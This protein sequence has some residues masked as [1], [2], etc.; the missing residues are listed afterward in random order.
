MALNFGRAGGTAAVSIDE[1]RCT[2]CGL[3]VQVC[4]GGPLTMQGGYSSSGGRVHVDQTRYWGCIGCGHCMTVCPQGCIL[5]EGR[6][7]SPQDRIEIPAPAARAGYES[8]YALLLSRR[9]TRAFRDQEVE[10]EV[11]DQILDAASTAP[12][13]I[14]PSEVSVLVLSGREAVT[15]FRDDLLNGM[16]SMRWMFSPF[17]LALLRPFLGRETAKLFKSFVAPAVDAYVDQD[18]QGADW[19]FYDAPLAL[20]FYASRYADPADPLI[21]ATYAMLAGE[22]LGLGSCMLGFPAY[23]LQYHRKLRTK[24]NLP[25]KI[26]PGI[27]VIFG[28]PALRHRRALKRRFAQV[29]YL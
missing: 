26:Q 7:L 16:Q 20:Y 2:A 15:A 5:V 9:S 1:E 3:C 11:I 24:Y 17:V 23:V 4:K 10:R 25:H 18:R 19:F 14:P 21:P 29:Q 22:S 28:Y 27:V 12:M 8:L 13:G 6:D